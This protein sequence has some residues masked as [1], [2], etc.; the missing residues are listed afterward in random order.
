M[1]GAY[2]GDVDWDVDDRGQGRP[3]VLLS[4]FGLDRS[5]M[6]LSFEPIFDEVGGWRRLYVNLPGMGGT[7]VRPANADGIVEA[8]VAY[9]ETELGAEPYALVGCS[10]GGYL[11]SA[12]ARRDAARLAGLL[13]VC[14]GVRIRERRLPPAPSDQEAGWLDDAPTELAAHLDLALGHRTRA[15]AA[16]VATLLS[17]ADTG[18]DDYLRRLRAEGY[19]LSDE[20]SADVYAGPVTVLTGR[21][22]RIGGYVDQFDAM[23]RYPQGT[24]AVIDG[25]GHYLPLEQPDLC[26]QLTLDWLSRLKVR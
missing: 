4:W 10:Y 5:A 16:R 22:D 24:Y 26:K 19:L 2:V 7:T 12:I 1:A 9:L 3:I 17:S 23:A 18:D 20:D 8:L 13:L 25:A 6:S 11:A 15:V 21:Q 14:S